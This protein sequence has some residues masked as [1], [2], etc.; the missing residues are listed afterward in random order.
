MF[1]LGIIFVILFSSEKTEVYEGLGIIR[2]FLM[3]F[4]I[5]SGD[6]STENYRYQGSTVMISLSW[7]IWLIAMLILSIL[8]MNFTIAV[9]SDSY[10][11][12]MQKLVAQSFKVKAEM[13]VQRELLL[14]PQNE[15]ESRFYF[16]E[17]IVLRRPIETIKGDS[18][19][20]KGFIKDLKQ[21]IQTSAQRSKN[22]VIQNVIPLQNKIEL[23]DKNTSN[24]QNTLVE[25]KTFIQ[26][27]YADKEE[28]KNLNSK[29]ESLAVKL[30]GCEIALEQL[31]ANIMK[32]LEK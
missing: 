9:I 29:V 31:N 26:T 32:L 1:Q 22:E 30:Q 11:K 2:Y 27:H 6:F 8:F 19:E 24:Q 16:P 5:Q 7:A 20:W 28:I 13:I 4:R 14:T 15:V 18:G 23:L 3:I 21:T 10:E 12:V 25:L 17:Y